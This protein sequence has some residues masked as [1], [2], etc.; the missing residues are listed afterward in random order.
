MISKL[1]KFLNRELIH[2]LRAIMLKRLRKQKLNRLIQVNFNTM[3]IRLLRRLNLCKMI[4]LIRC[5]RSLRRRVHLSLSGNKLKHKVKPKRK[6]LWDKIK[7]LHFRL[8]NIQLNQMIT[9]PFHSIGLMLMKKTTVLIFSSL[10]KFGNQ[11]PIPMFH[12]LSK[13]K[14]WKELYLLYQR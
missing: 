13:L 6:C 11:K 12:A 5:K 4:R 9:E 7:I 1:L 14:V 10:V 2:L 8:L 3:S